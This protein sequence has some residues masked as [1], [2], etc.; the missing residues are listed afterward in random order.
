MRLSRV[1][2]VT[3]VCTR[4]GSNTDMDTF[5]SSPAVRLA[6]EDAH[7]GELLLDEGLAL[8]GGGRQ[9][10]ARR[11]DRAAHDHHAALERGGILVFEQVPEPRHLVL[12]LARAHS[13]AM[14][15]SNSAAHRFGQTEPAAE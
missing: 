1:N 9:R 8:L 13:P 7:V 14:Q 11:P 12:Q 5:S 10:R 3:G 6:L 4:P 15:A 2:G